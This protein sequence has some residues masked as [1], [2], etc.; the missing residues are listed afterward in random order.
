MEQLPNLIYVHDYRVEITGDKVKWDDMLPMEYFD[1]FQAFAGQ[2]ILLSRVI[3]T[4]GQLTKP[5]TDF[6][7]ISD[8]SS[9]SYLEILFK[10][11]MS[12]KYLKTKVFVVNFP[13]IIGLMLFLIIRPKHYIIEHVNDDNLFKSKRFGWLVT[14]CIKLMKNRIFKKSLGAINVAQY[15]YFDSYP[16]IYT[17]ASNVM[18][19]D[20]RYLKSGIEEST[21]K[22]SM[23]GAV[24]KKKGTDLAIKALINCDFDFKLYICGEELDQSIRQIIPQS[25]EHKI[26]FLGKLTQEETHRVVTDCDIHLQPSRAEGLPRAL[27][28]AMALGRPCITSQLTCFHDLVPETL[29]VSFNDVNEF[30]TAISYLKSR[31]NYCLI[32]LENLGIVQKYSRT[33]L[34]L[35]RTE[36]YRKALENRPK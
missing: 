12:R 26:V 18:V 16:K 2:V 11:I 7:Q 5:S 3:G 35:R 15:L 25:L 34:E 28:E 36:F 20:L 17:T 29:R 14:S 1:R 6:V 27:I 22:F 10:I 8:I 19:P 13:T 30:K 21:I 24:S 33:S 4:P 32:A 31:E 9:R 23:A